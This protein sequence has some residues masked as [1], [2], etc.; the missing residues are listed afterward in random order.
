MKRNTITKIGASALLALGLVGGA[1]T[2][3][4]ANSHSKA[5]DTAEA[6]SFLAAS[7]SIADAIAA[8]EA[9]SGGKAMTAEFESDGPDAGWYKVELALADGSVSELLVNPADGT[10]KVAPADDMDHD[11]AGDNADEDGAENDS[12]EHGGENESN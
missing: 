1:A 5:G 6:Q 11:G 10:V 3:A 8:A 9:Q 7:G 4:S 12:D 2:M